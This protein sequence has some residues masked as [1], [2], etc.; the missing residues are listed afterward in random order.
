MSQSEGFQAGGGGGPTGGGLNMKAFLKTAMEAM[1]RVALI[2]RGT[3]WGTGFLVGDNLLLTNSH[4]LETGALSEYE[5]IFD[6]VDEGSDL[7]QLPSAKIAAS[8][9]QSPKEDM[10]YHLVRL[11]KSVG[12]ERGFFRFMET[13]YAKG[14]KIALFGFPHKDKQLQPLQF[15]PGQ[16]ETFIMQPKFK[17]IGYSAET[18]PGS[19]GSPVVALGGGVLGLHHWGEQGA[20]NFGIP[21][22]AL[23]TDLT[24]AN[25]KLVQ[26]FLS[27]KGP[28]LG[29][30][31]PSGLESMTGD[32]DVP[33]PPPHKSGIKE[34]VALLKR[35]TSLRETQFNQTLVILDGLR[36][37]HDRCTAEVGE[38][39]PVIERVPRLL[40]WLGSPGRPHME[41]LLETLD[42]MNY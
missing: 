38:S 26:L 20:D 28:D 24:V 34:R 17:R 3:G 25:R 41:E 9:Q 37:A 11:N 7:S 33:T 22:K 12:G 15:L 27:A 16:I 40:N 2:R 39:G 42:I 32:V 8:I 13:E 14:Q 30:A 23:L 18:R 21:S 6:F 29:F 4:V 19:S 1:P 5:V 31:G 36:P 35:L 10:D